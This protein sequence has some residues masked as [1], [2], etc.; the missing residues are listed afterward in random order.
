MK[1]LSVADDIVPL[2]EF[3]ARASKLLDE[4]PKRRHPI[5]IT[6]NGRPAGVVISPGDYDRLVERQRY[7]QDIAAGLADAEAGRVLSTDELLESLGIRRDARQ[8]E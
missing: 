8:A 7:L 6:R 3:K 4:L 2:G 5:V 1:P